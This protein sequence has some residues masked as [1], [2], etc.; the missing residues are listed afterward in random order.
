MGQMLQAFA[1]SSLKMY[2]PVVVEVVDKTLK[3]C[4]GQ[5][6]VNAYVH[7]LDNLS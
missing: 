2:H 7:T 5:P 1:E 3:Q 4:L 6:S